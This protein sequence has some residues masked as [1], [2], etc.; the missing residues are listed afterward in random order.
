MGA[1]AF[2]TVALFAL[3]GAGCAALPPAY[4]PALRQ[5]GEVRIYLQPIPQE[6]H[7]LRVEIS[8]VSAIRNDGIVLPLQ[9]AFE[10]LRAKELLG[11]QKLFASGQLPPGS[12]RGIEVGIRS[13][14]LQT[15]E[16][17]A[18]LLVPDV[19]LLVEREFTV[20]RERAQVLFLSLGDPPSVTAGFRFTPTFSLSKPRR[21][22]F[23]LLGFATNSGSNTLSVFNKFTM[24]VVDAI[25]TGSGPKGVVLDRVR[26]WLYVALAGEDAIEVFDVKT[27]EIIRRVG[28]N[29][30]DEPVEIGLSPDRE[31]LVTANRGSN[32]ASVLDARSLRE[33]ARVRLP[34]E[35]TSLVV[36]P[37]EARA[38]LFQPLSNSISAV[39][40]S[41]GE[42]A[43][44]VSFDEPPMRGAMS[45]EGEILY[46]ITGSSPNLL[47]LD[48]TSLGVREKIFVGGGTA[49]IQVDPTTGLLYVGDAF[50]EV[51]VIDASLLMPIDMF[52]VAGKAVYL[53]IGNEE[54]SLFVVLPNS[55]TI[56][57]IDLVSQR[58]LGSIE[59]EE[60]CYAVVLM[61]GR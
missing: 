29:F 58:L 35:P 1:A 49:S 6:A 15:D 37:T 16:G 14:S 40:L 22:L 44:T 45:S 42:S 31:R 38:Y 18:D 34:S 52:K 12:Y 53:S 60:G 25:A 26:G 54:N 59:V 21:Q 30:G 7:R 10:E 11:V 24:E 17:V 28:L 20:T 4:Q 61:G 27:G 36:S 43:V 55:N 2:G 13:A 47:V 50:G 23:S 51:A 8:G 41:R 3:L 9:L 19:P 33:I 39:D 5:N 57:K 46:V 32:S 56:Q 48:S